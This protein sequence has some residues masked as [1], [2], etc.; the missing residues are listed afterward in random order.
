MAELVTLGELQAQVVEAGGLVVGLHA[1]GRVFQGVGA[2]EQHRTEVEVVAQGAQLV[3]D[4]RGVG[5]LAVGGD[6]I[7]VGVG[8][9]GLGDVGHLHHAVEGEVAQLDELPFEQHH[10]V[11]CGGLVGDVLQCG[12]SLDVAVDDGDAVDELLGS[13]HLNVSLCLFFVAARDEAIDNLGH[14]VL[15][16]LLIIRWMGIMG[17]IGWMGFYGSDGPTTPN[18]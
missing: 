7:V 18:S 10:G 2:E 17:F 15:S 5:A 13:Q 1:C 11:G 3:V 6:I 9:A 16:F 4:G 12:R 14:C 8:H